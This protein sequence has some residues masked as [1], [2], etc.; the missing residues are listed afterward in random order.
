M[1]QV[2]EIITHYPV[3]GIHFDDYFYPTNEKKYNKVSKAE[4]KKNVNAMVKKVYQ[5]VKAK[6][7]N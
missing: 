5:T 4:R 6:V 2:Q 3:D 7:L 1:R